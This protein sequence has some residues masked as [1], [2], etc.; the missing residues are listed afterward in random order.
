MYYPCLY[1]TPLYLD[2]IMVDLVGVFYRFSLY[3]HLF[4]VISILYLYL[5]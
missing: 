4:H 3:F 2:Q 5:F 1:I